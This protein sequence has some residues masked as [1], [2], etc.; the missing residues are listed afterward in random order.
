MAEHVL[1]QQVGRRG[2]AHG[3]AGVTRACFLHRIHG[4]DPDQV[5]GAPVGFGPLQ[6]GRACSLG[7]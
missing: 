1:V 3:G 5:H 6:G 4:Q 2:Q 7:I